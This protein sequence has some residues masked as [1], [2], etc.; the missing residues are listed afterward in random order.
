MSLG[1]KH[2]P[3]S[4]R[5]FNHC[6][7]AVKNQT[8]FSYIY[9]PP[10][11]P[12]LATHHHNTG[13]NVIELQHAAEDHCWSLPTST[14]L[15]KNLILYWKSSW[16]I[17]K[18]N[19]L[20]PI[21]SLKQGHIC[22]CW[23]YL[24]NIFSFIILFCTQVVTFEGKV[25]SCCKRLCNTLYVVRF[26]FDMLAT[27]VPTTDLTSLSLLHELCLATVSLM[28]NDGKKTSTPAL[29]LHGW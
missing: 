11:L 28:V 17:D 13:L 25:C 4:L 9:I 27:D 14:V 7:Q 24:D 1:A 16:V 6:H 15:Q 21:C 22:V 3:Y 26:Q 19:I 29:T 8:T 10:L 12:Y 20:T 2:P 5:W 18:I 23:Y